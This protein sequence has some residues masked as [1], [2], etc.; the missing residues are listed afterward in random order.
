MFIRGPTRSLLLRRT[1]SLHSVFLCV[2]RH[3]HITEHFLFLNHSICH[4][5]VFHGCKITFEP[6]L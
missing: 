3:R 4:W 1:S 5:H 2:V 6:N